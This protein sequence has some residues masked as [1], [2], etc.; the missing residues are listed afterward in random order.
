MNRTRLGSSDFIPQRF[1]Y[2]AQALQPPHAIAGE[3]GV[4]VPELNDVVPVTRVVL[5]IS[6]A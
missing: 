6:P 5:S 3:Q 1:V 4:Q 2:I